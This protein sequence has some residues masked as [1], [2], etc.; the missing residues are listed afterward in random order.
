VL[1]T[2]PVPVR[3]R[4]PAVPARLAEVIDVALAEPPA[5]GFQTAADLR[6]AIEAA[7]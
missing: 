6:R 7:L 4:D 5:A 2:A 3:R 1:D